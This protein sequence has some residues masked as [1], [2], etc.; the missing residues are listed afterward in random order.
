MKNCNRFIKL[1][2]ISVDKQ[3][4]LLYGFSV[5]T[6]Q[7]PRSWQK[8]R[9]GKRRIDV[10]SAILP[11]EEAEIFEQHLAG[12]NSISLNA[13]NLLAPGLIPR[14][15]VLSYGAAWE[16]PTPISQ[17][18][19]VHELWNIRK[20]DLVQQLQIALGSQGRDLY[21]DIQSLLAQL[22]NECGVDFSQHG[23][24]LGNY[25]HYDDVP[26]Y[27]PL[28]INCDEASE[29]KRMLVRKP[30]DWARP[31]VVNCI[32]QRQERV[33]FNQIHYL[34]PEDIQV[35]FA[36]EETIGLC[37]VYAWDQETGELVFFKS[38]P[39]CNQLI[40][41]LS[42]DGPSRVVRDP[43]TES[44]YSAASNR[45]DLIHQRIEMVQRRSSDHSVQIGGRNFITAAA[46]VGEHLLSPYGAKPCK[47][48]FIPKNQK[49]GEISSFLKVR[50]YLNQDSVR[51]AVIADPYFSVPTA[52]KILFRIANTNLELTVV[53][54]LT[55]TDPDTEE[56]KDS[57]VETYQQFLRDNA[58]GLHKKL[59]VC[60]LYRGKKRALHD[61]YLIRYHA[62]GHIDGFLLSNSLNS[63]GQFYPFVVAPLEPEVCLAVAEYLQQLQDEGFQKKRPKTERISCQVLYDYR[64]RFSAE[65]S[66][67]EEP[68]GQEWLARWTDWK[69]P[70]EELPDA[71]NAVL[72][73][74]EEAPEEALR[75]LSLLGG[76]TNTW[77]AANLATLLHANPAVTEEY[78]DRFSNKI[79][80]V[81][82]ARNHQEIESDLQ[83]YTLW[84]LLAEK[85]KPDRMGFKGLLENKHTVYYRRYEWLSGGCCLLLALDPARFTAL[86]ETTCSPLMLG[87]LTEY[88]SIWP[89][90]ESLYRCLLGSENFCIRLLA[91]HWPIVLLDRERGGLTLEAVLPLLDSLKPGPGLLQSARLL[92]EAAFRIRN[93]KPES[94]CWPD[95]L[96]VLIDYTAAVL[97]RCTPEE[98]QTGLHW[99][100][101]CEV[102]SWCN[103]YLKVAAQVEEESIRKELLEKAVAVMQEYLTTPRYDHD[104]SQHIMLCLDALEERFG[105]QVEQEL[106]KRLVDWTVFETA[107]EPARGDYDYTRWH[108]AHLRAQW[109]IQLLRAF[110]DRHPQAEDTK[111]CLDQW[112]KRVEI[113]R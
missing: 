87:C 23:A 48:V 44:L 79:R 32:A 80:E 104:I 56:E 109:Q 17:L 13:L 51:R 98:R 20:E 39:L 57:I 72:C 36:A 22:R 53:T 91:V 41:N 42:I 102:C 81:E 21:Q 69:I 16:E 4:L 100:H 70:V 94:G 93:P 103:L 63:M 71:L 46:Q 67:P 96:P 64:D 24:R 8:K 84:C 28:E 6:E 45:S 19:C 54:S 43:W 55:D 86:M 50:E 38:F 106:H 47:G 76:H 18:S 9:Q 35:E 58:M 88:L 15:P 1:L 66:L 34:G 59:R 78:I 29:G 60:N 10:S 14:K 33:L 5:P 112:E 90:S 65:E 11:S 107:T 92:S 3:D 83:E 61:R 111:K 85:S 2:T 113:M 25:E 89:W 75:A 77:N 82:E 49:D 40:F 108:A 37:T 52:A 99:L 101:D 95:L 26:L 7:D 62:D 27:C 31:L 74:W 105:P 68:A 30:V 97:T 12:E 110:L 73:H